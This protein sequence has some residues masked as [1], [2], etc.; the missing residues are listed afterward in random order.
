MW[1]FIL[2]PHTLRALSQ[3]VQNSGFLRN[4]MSEGPHRVATAEAKAGRA[5]LTLISSCLGLSRPDVR[6]SELETSTPVSQV[7]L[8]AFSHCLSKTHGKRR[9]G[10]KA[11]F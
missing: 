7:M 3:H 6:A 2:G 4:S 8:I 11:F 9:S 10:G 5:L 1:L